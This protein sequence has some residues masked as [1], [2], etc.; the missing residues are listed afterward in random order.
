MT[1]NSISVSLPQLAQ[2]IARKEA[3]R[4]EMERVRMELVLE[5]QE[6]RERQ[7]EM[8]SREDERGRL[9]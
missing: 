3:E 2:D 9:Q 1:T 4:V 8:V 6:E 5:E 7:R